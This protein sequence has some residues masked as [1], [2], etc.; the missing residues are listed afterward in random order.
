MLSNQLLRSSEVDKT[1]SS[2]G[3]F[4]TVKSLERL[5]KSLARYHE[6]GKHLVHGFIASDGVEDTRQSLREDLAQTRKLI[7]ELRS[8]IIRFHESP[9]PVLEVAWNAT[10]SDRSGYIMWQRIPRGSDN[11]LPFVK[12]YPDTGE[13][14]GH[15]FEQKLW[16]TNKI[17]NS[18]SKI[19]FNLSCVSGVSGILSLGFVHP[20]ISVALGA[21]FII[22]WATNLVLTSKKIYSSWWYSNIM[23]NLIPLDKFSNMLDS[24]EKEINKILKEISSTLPA[25]PSASS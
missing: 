4:R 24:A 17:V 12:I 16:R 11:Y 19:S 6:C 3:L 20:A 2:A 25:R 15:F 9:N 21:T 7:L 8:S 23:D 5:D 18:C 14:V 10:S 1:A 13:P 22:S